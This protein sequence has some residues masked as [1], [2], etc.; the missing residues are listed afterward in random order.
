MEGER[1]PYGRLNRQE[2]RA[3]RQALGEG[4]SERRRRRNT[5]FEGAIKRYAGETYY[6][7]P[8]LKATHYRWLVIVYFFV[9][10]IASASQFIATI[11]DLLGHKQDRS[12]VRIGRYLALAGSII[13]PILLILDLHTPQRFYNM[14]R[15]YRR[16]S[17]MSIGSWALFTFGTLSGLTA[18]AQFMADLTKIGLFRSLARIT[19][20][21]SALAGGLVALYTGTLLAATSNPLWSSAF[22][23]LSSLF[24]SSAATTGSAALALIGE[25][26][27]ISRG[28]HK[29]L[30]YFGLAVEIAELTLVTIITRRWQKAGVAAPLNEQ[31]LA[32]VYRFGA[33]G[34]GMV[35]PIT[36]H[37]LHILTG[38]Y[39]HITA[40]IAGIATL[41]GGFCLRTSVILAGNK[42]AN[43]PAD[44]FRITQ[45]SGEILSPDGNRST[46]TNGGSQP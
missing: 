25:M 19:S 31:P 24:A 44:Y 39:R 7:L 8:A 38:R 14:L 32:S 4:G 20:I 27:H 36:L 43:R 10:G 46:T 42:S 40:L 6:D 22:P 11:V 28:T 12:L 17:P 41:A 18:V 34:L 23:L 15:I 21:P 45:P 29:R 16:T 9:G 13:S 35:V 37:L 1:A 2:D 26:T 30:E 5:S 33:I 3:E